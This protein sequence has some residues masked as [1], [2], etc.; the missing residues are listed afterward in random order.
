MTVDATSNGLPHRLA[1]DRI[2]F[3]HRRPVWMIHAVAL[4]IF[5]LGQFHVGS[6]L[7]DV[8]DDATRLRFYV[9]PVHADIVSF[10]LF[11]PHSQAHLI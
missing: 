9:F 1:D 5:V 8:I 3:M 4:F 10:S 11:L 6:P 7:I 2:V